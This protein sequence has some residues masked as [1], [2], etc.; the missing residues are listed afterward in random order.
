MFE[1]GGR[2]RYAPTVS[3]NFQRHLI[4]IM[5][6][7]LILCILVH[8]MILV[9]PLIPSILVQIPNPSYL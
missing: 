1:W 2:I 3:G 4:I 7:P 5:V 6:Y 8:S 9:Y